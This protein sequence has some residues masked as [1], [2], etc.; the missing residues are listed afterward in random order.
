MIKDQQAKAEIAQD[1]SVV[2]KLCKEGRTWLIPGA[3]VVSETYPE[4]YYNLPL[5]L[6]YAVLDRVLTELR[7]QGEFACRGWLLGAKMAASQ[8]V[9]PWQ[10]YDL[11]NG[12]KE[13]RNN[14]A[15]DAVLTSK[16]DCLRF[17]DAV[18]TELKAWGI[19]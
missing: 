15:H 12:G 7:D 9:L 6:G 8:S 10:D 5:V 11:V 16:T 1:W 13:A 17:I 18:E 3:G 19:V 2:R 14:L 4:D